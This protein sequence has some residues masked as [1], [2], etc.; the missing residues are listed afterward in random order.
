MILNPPANVV[1]FLQNQ[2]FKEPVRVQ[3]IYD[4]HPDIRE[5]CIRRFLFAGCLTGRQLM[6][7]F[8]EDGCSRIVWEECSTKIAGFSEGVFPADLDHMVRVVEKWK[9]KLVLA[10]GRVADKAINEVLRRYGRTGGYFEILTAPHPAAR[11]FVR[12]S[13]LE[14]LKDMR[15]HHL[16]QRYLYQDGK[17]MDQRGR[18]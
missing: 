7:A 14:D 18:N 10:F 2:W 6:K 9:P 11:Q 1:A 12:Q 15:K 3:R 17:I 16:C 8:G 5:Q 4:Q 13:V